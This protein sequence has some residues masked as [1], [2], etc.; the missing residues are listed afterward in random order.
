MLVGRWMRGYCKGDVVE[1]PQ[2]GSRFCMRDGRVLTGPATVN[3]P[4]Y[5]VYV[6]NGQV[7]VK[8]VNEH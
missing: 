1:C 3:V 8:L 5:D 4:R 2:Q 6:R 7:L